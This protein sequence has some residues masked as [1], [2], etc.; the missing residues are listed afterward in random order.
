LKINPDPRMLYELDILYEKSNV[1]MEKRAGLFKEYA[2]VSS[3]RVDALTRQVL[4]SIQ[5]EEYDDAIN[6]LH[7]NYFY[8]WEGGNEVREYYED[9][10]LLRGV[11]YLGKGKLKK[12]RTDF[13]AALEY[14]ENLEEGRPEFDE[15]F[16]RSYYYNGLV[17]ERMGESAAAEEYYRKAAAE[18]TAYSEFIYYNILALEKLGKIQEREVQIKNLQRYAERGS[19]DRFFAKFGERQSQQMKQ[20]EL[21]YLQGLVAMV[22]SQSDEA[23]TAFQKAIELNPNHSWAKAHL[24]ELD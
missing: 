23:R 20:A 10:H 21:Q 1:D 17:L 4:V 7:D 14:P 19:G 24:S 3:R 13:E 5:S 11:S 6:L 22:K 2:S 15:A 16:A 18:R 12:A 9:A 8:R